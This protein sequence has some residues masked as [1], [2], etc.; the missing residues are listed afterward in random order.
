MNFDKVSFWL[1]NFL[2]ISSLCVSSCQSEIEDSF[3][4]ISKKYQEVDP[5]LTQQLLIPFLENGR[6]G[7]A[8]FE[9]NIKLMP[10]FSHL[11]MINLACP[12]FWAGGENTMTLR[13]L[14]G[15]EVLDYKNKSI[16]ESFIRF[17]QLEWYDEDIPRYD[18]LLRILENEEEAKKDSKKARYYYINENT[19]RPIRSY[20]LQDY[21][22]LKEFYS[23]H[24]LENFQSD[25]GIDSNVKVMT[26]NG[27][28]TFLDKNGNQ[29][30]APNF[31][32]YLL[33][34]DKM[35]LYGEGGLAALKDLKTGWQTDFLFQKIR[36]T[37]N[38]NIF[39]AEIFNE[40]D[41]TTSKFIIGKNGKVT[42]LDVM[43]GE[44]WKVINEKYSLRQKKDDEDK[45]KTN[46]WLFDN[47]T[48][49]KVKDL[50]TGCLLYTS[51]A[52]DE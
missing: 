15:K 29:L 23:K 4:F 46:Y 36:T 25:N 27:K 52:A 33:V 10:Q 28:F 49:T 48:F 39:T 24:R 6:Y 8:D 30:I 35:I 31:N 5:E 9:G 50:P 51:D 21:D 47:N 40:K 13:D 20:L 42:Q 1:V 2:I 34:D 18:L 12:F 7:L 3:P 16:K 17:E 44:R 41:R 37:T 11:K 22:H 26:E 45:Y 19:K 14:K 43:G 32:C 38:P